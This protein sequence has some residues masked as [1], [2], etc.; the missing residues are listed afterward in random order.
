MEF[1]PNQSGQAFVDTLA[2]ESVRAYLAQMSLISDVDVTESSV[3]YKNS[4]GLEPQGVFQFG[5]DPNLPY[6]LGPRVTGERAY[7]FS[8]ALG[9]ARMVR[10]HPFKPLVTVN[11]ERS[12][13][14][15]LKSSASYE[16]QIELFPVIRRH[17]E[18]NFTLYNAPLKVSRLLAGR[19]WEARFSAYN[20]DSDYDPNYRVECSDKCTGS[21]PN[22]DMGM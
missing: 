1:W 6:W 4:F 19:T 12:L 5:I 13:K 2:P 17:E 10:H 8:D 18:L 22:F 7:H 14:V 15:F 9:T 21:L 20:D 11:H 16:E 3:Y